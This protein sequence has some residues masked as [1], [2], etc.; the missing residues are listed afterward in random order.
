MRLLGQFFF[1]VIL[2]LSLSGCFELDY[3]LSSVTGHLQIISRR[4]SISDLLQQKTTPT[5]LQQRLEEITEIRDYASRKLFLPEN[6][7][8][9]SYV[10]LD[11]PYVV[12]NVVATPEFSLTPLQWCFPIAGCV[13]YRGYFDLDQAKEFARSLDSDHFDTAVIGS[14]AYSTLQWFDDPVLSTFSDWPLPSIAK[15]IFH[16]LAHQ[17][18]YVQ[19]DSVFNESFATTVGQIG[20]D[21]WL[22]ERGDPEM[23]LHYRQQQKR[24]Q[25]F[26][27]R[28]LTTRQ[29][30]EKLYDS[31]QPEVEMHAAKLAIFDNLRQ[32]YVQLR[33]S[34]QGTGA[35]MPGSARSIMR[36]LPQSIPTIAGCRPS[37]WFLR[38][39]TKICSPFIAAVRR[40][41][42]SRKNN[43]NNCWKPFSPR[44]GR[45]ITILNY[46][47]LILCLTQNLLRLS[48]QLSNSKFITLNRLLKV[49]LIIPHQ[50]GR[51]AAQ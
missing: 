24:Q 3:Y 26:N 13:T 28:L 34:W 45:K 22:Q 19:D 12:W 7:S 29:E 2:T 51:Y 42:S 35:M 43:A 39:S 36:A 8:Y 9:R 44:L 37:N 27:E 16:E 5:D 30:L 49:T 38:R 48:L 46:R 47:F 10:K 33:E 18:L 4:Q 41:P 6:G 31:K 21:L 15:L 32:S 23:T 40:L 20:I 11:R 1:C 14:P 17:K 50:E 25:Q